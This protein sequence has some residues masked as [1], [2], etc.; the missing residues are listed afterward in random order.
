MEAQSEQAASWVRQVPDADLRSLA[1]AS[2]R[3]QAVQS[4]FVAS[5]P[6]AAAPALLLLLLLPISSPYRSRCL[7]LTA[8]MQPVL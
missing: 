5:A 4:S 6:G 1:A 8:H 2:D 7:Q 3:V